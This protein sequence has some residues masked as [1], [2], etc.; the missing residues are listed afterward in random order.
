MNTK[1][2]QNVPQNEA[3]KESTFN[4]AYATMDPQATLAPQI[5]KERGREIKY[6]TPMDEYDHYYSPPGER[7]TNVT[8][9]NKQESCSAIQRGR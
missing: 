5:Q 6:S 2:K 7:S 1:T 9:L 3:V 4:G 8:E